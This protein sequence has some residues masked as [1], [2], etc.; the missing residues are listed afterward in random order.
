MVTP[1]LL[2]AARRPESPTA[3][4]RARRRLAVCLQLDA[5]AEEPQVS[6]ELSKSK[7]P[8]MPKWHSFRKAVILPVI[9]VSPPSAR[10]EEG[11]GSGPERAVV[12]LLPSPSFLSPKR[13]AW[14]Y[15]EGLCC[16]AL[17]ENI[18]CSRLSPGTPT[19]RIGGSDDRMW[20]SDCQTTASAAINTPPPDFY[21]T[22]PE[23]GG[24]HYYR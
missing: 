1:L 9:D 21:A 19:L 5:P 14:S 8:S 24:G 7:A 15:S 13:A 12:V 17:S 11:E 22:W 2:A 23:A 18:R 10:G 6:P 3:E 4:G 20:S 16:R